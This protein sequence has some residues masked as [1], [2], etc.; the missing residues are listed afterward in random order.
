MFPIRL[1][2]DPI[3]LIVIFPVSAWMVK[4]LPTPVISFIATLDPLVFI[5]RSAPLKSSIVPLAPPLKLR[6]P[7]AHSV[8]AEPLLKSKTVPAVYD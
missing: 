4:F 5:V 6:V 1:P 8:V 2:R 3:E 7:L